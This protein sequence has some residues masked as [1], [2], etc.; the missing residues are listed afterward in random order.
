TLRCASV[1]HARSPST[2]ARG[3]LDVHDLAELHRISQEY[4]ASL[5]EENLDHAARGLDRLLGK[6]LDCA[7]N[8]EVER[9]LRP[10]QTRFV[11]VVRLYGGAAGHEVFARHVAEHEVLAAELDTAARP[12]LIAHLHR[13]I[14]ELRAVI[15]A[16]EDEPWRRPATVP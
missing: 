2:W 8:P 15:G 9:V 1:E 4:V 14:A 16:A 5:H 10:L 6:L 11:R 12:Q 3:W 13:R 7:R